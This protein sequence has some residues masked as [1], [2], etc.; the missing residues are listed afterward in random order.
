[1]K[2]LAIIGVTASVVAAAGVLYVAARAYDAYR[3]LF[4]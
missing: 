1:M 2:V 4:G 3:R